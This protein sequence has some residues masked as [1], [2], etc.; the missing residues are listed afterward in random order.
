MKAQ[1]QY[2]NNLQQANLSL[3]SKVKQLEELKSR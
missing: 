3:K 1:H 2:I